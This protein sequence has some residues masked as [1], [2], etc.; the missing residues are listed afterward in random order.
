MGAKLFIGTP[1]P[2]RNKK[3]RCPKK[4][5]YGLCENAWFP[6]RPIADLRMGVCLSHSPYQF[7]RTPSFRI[8]GVPM[9][10]LAPMKKSPG[11]GAARQPKLD[12]GVI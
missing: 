3:R 2:P 11:D 9:N 4:N 12:A 7:F 1:P 6:W 10:D 8:L 5:W